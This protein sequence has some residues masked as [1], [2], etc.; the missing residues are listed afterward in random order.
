MAYES[1]EL[2]ENP[3]WQRRQEHEEKRQNEEAETK[4][5]KGSIIALMTVCVALDLIEYGIDALAG[6]YAVG[7]IINLCIDYCAEIIFGVWLSILGISLMKTR[8]VIVF[9]GG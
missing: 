6:E 9:F 4:L 7:E 2:K 5:S 8:N 3:A 1:E